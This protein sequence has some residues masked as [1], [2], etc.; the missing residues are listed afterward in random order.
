MEK[1]AWETLKA[2]KP[3]LPRWRS[4]T[5]PRTNPEKPKQVFAN[6]KDE[7]SKVGRFKHPYKQVNVQSKS[8]EPKTIMYHPT[9]PHPNTTKRRSVRLTQKA[10][11]KV[12]R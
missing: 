12:N 8:G 1:S 5:A 2:I 10:A 6:R 11:R 3:A 9:K 7:R 4:R